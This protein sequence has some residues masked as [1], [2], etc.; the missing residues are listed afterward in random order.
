[1]LTNH[2]HIVIARAPRR[3][4]KKPA[5]PKLTRIIVGPREPP[6]PPVA[7]V[8]AARGKPAAKPAAVI[9]GRKAEPPIS[10]EEYKA[11]GDAADRLFREMVRRVEEGRGR[12]DERPPKRRSR[13][14]SG[15]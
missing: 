4:R 5:G 3:A 7:E 13:A 11:R 6:P 14:D 15:P 12:K 9:V 10:E 1:V 2:P 8:H